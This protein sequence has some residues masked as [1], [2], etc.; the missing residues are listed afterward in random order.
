M[1][2]VRECGLMWL[3]EDWRLER[4]HVGEDECVASTRAC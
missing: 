2:K 1:E 4:K 3:R